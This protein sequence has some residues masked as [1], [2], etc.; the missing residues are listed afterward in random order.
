MNMSNYKKGGLDFKYEV[1]K[2]SGR[3]TDPN[4]KYFVLRVDKDPHALAALLFYA[5]SVRK[6]NVLLSDNIMAW[7]KILSKQQEADDE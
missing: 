1:R 7:H 4:A 5:F 2:K 6:D 3:P